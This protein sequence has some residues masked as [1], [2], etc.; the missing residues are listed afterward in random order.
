MFLISVLRRSYIALKLKYVK[1]IG[2]DCMYE[3]IA[4]MHVTR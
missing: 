1:E 2:I 3:N 4:K